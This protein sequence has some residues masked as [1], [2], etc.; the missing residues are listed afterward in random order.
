VVDLGNSILLP[1]LINAHCH[2]DYTR[3]AGLIAPQKTFVDWIAAILALKAHWSYAEYAESWLHG[4]RTLIRKGVTMAGDIESVPE[5]L[6]EVTEATP[7]RV[8]SFIEMTGVKSQRPAQ[9]VLQE[10]LDQLRRAGCRAVG[11][12]PHSPYSTSA[13]LLRLC[14]RTARQ[15]N[16]RTAT[17][18]AE[19]SEEW[20]MFVSRSGPLFDWLKHQRDMSDCRGATPVHH[21]DA[22]GMLGENLLA[23]HANYLSADDVQ[24]LARSGTSVVHCPRSHE[25]FQHQR[26]PWEELHCSGINLCL[27]TDSLATARAGRARCRNW[28]CSP[29][30]AWPGAG[31]GC[32]RRR[33]SEAPR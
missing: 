22:C 19:S 18:V 20:E 12:S 1:G 31:T 14:S 23:I 5:L 11:L 15:R 16:W 32:S 28:I 3:M 17:H 21:L 9:L 10:A 29:R 33:W 7:L 26:F 30:C 8:L 2:L 25:Y 6:P 27:G 24:R 4:A 13:E